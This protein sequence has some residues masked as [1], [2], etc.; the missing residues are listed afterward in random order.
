MV[1]LPFQPILVHTQTL[2]HLRTIDIDEQESQLLVRI[3][4]DSLPQYNTFFFGEP[5][6]LV[7]DFFSAS[8][9][10]IPTQIDVNAF[11]VHRVRTAINRPGVIRLV[12]DLQDDLPDFKFH[13]SG[14]ELTVVFSFKIQEKKPPPAAPKKPIEAVKKDEFLEEQK[15]EEKKPEPVEEEIKAEQETK[16]LERDAAVKVYL[17]CVG[18]DID[19]IKKEITFVNYVRDR[20]VA[21]I[22]IFITTQMT[23]SGGR[24]YSINFIG[25]NEYSHI[26][27]TLMY[28]SKKTDTADVIRRGLVRVLKLGL[29]PFVYKTPVADKLLVHFLKELKPTAVEDKWNFW[30]FNMGINGNTAGEK[31]TKFLSFDGDL[32]V[33]RVT[34]ES[35]LRLGISVAFDENKYK[36]GDDTYISTS[37]SERFRSKYVKSLGDHWSMGVWANFDSSTY[38][39]I[40]SDFFW[41]VGVEYDIFPYSVSTRKL[42]TFSYQMGYNFTTY[43]EETIFF[44]MSEKLLGQSL[45]AMANFKQPWGYIFLILEGSHYFHDFSKNRLDL[46]TGFSVNF[47]KGLAFDVWGGYSRI[48]DQLSLARRG[49]T[50]EEILLRRKELATN[51]SYHL[52]V[53]L[54]YTFGSIYSNVVNPR[55]GR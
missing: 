11:G 14:T 1:F 41:S 28:F 5:N 10:S 50:H 24:E 37:H 40:K 3:N 38:S 13:K 15:Q 51:Y 52:S 17:D 49:A 47:L 45:T 39:N 8:R 6:R 9:F 31:T 12:F 42:L 2:G 19:F 21:D 18:C 25:Q 26:Q 53:G 34:P 23:G 4:F 20:N 36:F 43:R 48:H 22:H 35:K 55:F 30:V 54:S 32:S 46:E 44:K 7:F 33:N 16:G 29:I 27:D